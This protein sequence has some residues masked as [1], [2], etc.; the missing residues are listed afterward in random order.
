[1]NRDY[2]G[3]KMTGVLLVA[4]VA[5]VL[6]SAAVP[7]QGRAVVLTDDTF[8]SELDG[9][10]DGATWFLKLY[11]PWCGHCQKLAPVWEVLGEHFAGSETVHIGDV[12]CTE[13]PIICQRF[14]VRGFPTLILL[15]GDQVHS[16]GGYRSLD[17]LEAFVLGGYESAASTPLPPPFSADEKQRI[18]AKYEADKR[19]K[20]AAKQPE[21]QVVDDPH[22][23]SRVEELTP[24]TFQS[25]VTGPKR[26]F[27]MLYAPWCGHCKKLMPVWKKLSMEV[28]PAD[29]VIAQIDGSMYR[30]LAQRFGVNGFPT[31]LL[32]ENG[33]MAEFRS[34]RTL[35]QLRIFARTGMDDPN[36]PKKNVPAEPML[37][38]IESLIL[39][40][41]FFVADYVSLDNPYVVA[42]E[43]WMQ[44]NFA[45]AF[46]LACL[47]SMVLGVFTGF[48]AGLV[49]HSVLPSRRPKPAKFPS[50]EEIASA[51][52]AKSKKN[53]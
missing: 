44:H 46:V 40:L 23:P 38:P 19:A 27:V 36:I 29:V 20:E 3:N 11:A 26:A 43:S 32:F 28:D 31:V 49:A 53:E 51:A 37:P 42:V 4:V 30:D 7:V 48:L 16:Y 34:H 8:Q 39:S 17:D 12:D 35:D 45:T 13:Q 9:S 6:L 1:M 18:R 22:A 47:V 5:A 52:V 10:G 14:S 24:E 41:G 50:K 21:Q 15:H 2:F 25:L 33:R